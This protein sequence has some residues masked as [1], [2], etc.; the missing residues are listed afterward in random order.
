MGLYGA[1]TKDAVAA[2]G[3]AEVY[4]G[5]PYDNEVVL[6]YSDVDPVHNAAVA[7]PATCTSLHA[8]PLPGPVVPGQRRTLL[9][10]NGVT[11]TSRP[12]AP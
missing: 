6:F 7:E 12:A 10:G 3:P 2:A 9:D 11:P 4:D 8:D 5:V 1:V